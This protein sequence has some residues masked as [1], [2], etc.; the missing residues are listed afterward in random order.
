MPGDSTYI[1]LIDA[2]TAQGPLWLVAVVFS[3]IAAVLAWKL[4]PVIRE[5]TEGKIEIA[6]QREARKAEE[7][8]L[9]HERDREH[10]ANDARMVDAMNRQSDSAQAMAAALNTLST[11]IDA[12]QERSAHMGE[13]VD[14]MEDTV[15]DTNQMVREIH[16]VTVHSI[17]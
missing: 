13:Q 16:A 6:K 1:R 9:S 10:A 2:L 7:A 11:Q 4:I 5:S 8:R 12:S 3:I 17:R 14:G 15:H